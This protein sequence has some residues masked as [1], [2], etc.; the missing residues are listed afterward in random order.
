M[1]MRWPN[2]FSRPTAVDVPRRSMRPLQTA[3]THVLEIMKYEEYDALIER[4]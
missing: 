1:A 4:R 3:D 2:G